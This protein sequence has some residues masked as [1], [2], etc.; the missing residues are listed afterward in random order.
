[1]K[2]LLNCY[3]AVEEHMLLHILKSCKY[4]HSYRIYS[5]DIVI[6][7]DEIPIG[8]I[9][10]VTKI[11]H[12]QHNEFNHQN[13]I[14]IPKYLRTEEFLKRDYS[15][16]QGS[17]VPKAGYYFIKD[18]ETLK[19]FTYLGEMAYFD[20][21]GDAKI[22]PDQLYL[23]SSKFN[24]KSE[25]R[26][27]V[28]AGEIESICHYNGDCTVFPDIRLIKK[29]VNLIKL[30]EKWLQ[31]Y[32]IDVMVGNVGTAIIEIHNFTSVG[33][34]TTLISNYILYAYSDGISYLLNDNRKI[35]V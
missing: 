31:S 35:E 11:L 13:P 25:Y 1:M 28:I 24:I 17:D 16:V 26:V 2:F 3:D 29:A 22:Y 6:D 9:E 32:T 30:H 19:S 34:Y 4:T 27:Y 23:V 10:F 5:D 15:I 33:L 8:S 7:T 21:M 20:C 18:V 12:A 14:E